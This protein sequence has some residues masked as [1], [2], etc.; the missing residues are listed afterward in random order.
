L[1]DHRRRGATPQ[2][3]LL[4]QHDGPMQAYPYLH[5]PAMTFGGG[6][7]SAGGIQ[8]EAETFPTKPSRLTV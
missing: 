5:R 4:G 8:Q 3:A 6:E 1:L 7:I 2:Q